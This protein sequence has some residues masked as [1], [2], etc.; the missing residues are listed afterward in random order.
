LTYFLPEG[1]IGQVFQKFSWPDERL[2][3]SLVGLGA[4][5]GP[6]P[7]SLL[8]GSQS[9]PPYAVVGLGVGTLATHARPWQHMIFYEIDPLVERL[10]LPPK[11]K[12]AYFF[13]LQ[14]AIHRGAKLEVILGDGRLTLA[15]DPYLS[16]ENTGRR[17]EKYFHILVLDA[18]SSDAIP[19]HLLTAEA[20]DLY[21]SKLADGGLLIFN[22]TNRYVDIKPVLADIA[23]S[24]GLSAL[25]FG[26]S[27]SGSDWVV[28]QRK[29]FAGDRPAANGGPPLRQRFDERWQAPKGL[30]GP[31]WTDKYS[32][33]LRVLML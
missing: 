13:Y 12:P 11:G 10:S 4:S 27:T 5:S 21:L 7:G 22:T 1:G 32:N 33:L 20:I 31:I 30:G 3:A 23:D 9:E 15:K 29:E 19:V 17:F 8:V 14:D 28:L 16:H 25:Q 18:F 2:G 6:I 26:D 24:R